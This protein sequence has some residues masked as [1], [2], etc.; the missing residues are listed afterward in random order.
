MFV[1]T[2]FYVSTHIKKKCINIILFQ[3]FDNYYIIS[4]ICNILKV[5]S[6]CWPIYYIHAEL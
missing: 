4:V 3:I 6:H 2:Y 1:K 5:Y